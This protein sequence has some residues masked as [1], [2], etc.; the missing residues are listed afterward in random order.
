MDATRLLKIMYTVISTAMFS[1]RYCV[2]GTPQSEVRIYC[3]NR[4][5]TTELE[6]PL[7]GSRTVA[8]LCLLR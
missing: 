3:Q 7:E 5:V 4:V 6:P 8:V 2:H 1:S